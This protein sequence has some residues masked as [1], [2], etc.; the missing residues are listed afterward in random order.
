V[1]NAESGYIEVP[2]GKLYYEAAGGGEPVVF[3]H[4]F[5]LDTRM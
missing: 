5:T 2:G 1:V 4:G 3:V